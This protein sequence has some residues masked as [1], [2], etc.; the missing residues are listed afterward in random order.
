MFEDRDKILEE[1]EKELSFEEKEEDEEDEELEDDEDLSYDDESDEDSEDDDEEEEEDEEEDVVL[2]EDE[3][4][5]RPQ[6]RSKEEKTNFAFAE[7]RKQN[8][9][10][11]DKIDKLNDVAITYG[12]KDH[13][14][15]LKKLEE[16]AIVKKAKEQ[17]IDPTL[18]KRM[19]EQEKQLET[20]KREREEEKTAQKATIVLT[21]VNEFIKETGLPE[22]EKEGL[23]A[24]LDDDGFTIDTLA[25]IKNYKALFKGYV[26]D[27][28]LE[29]ERQKELAR[30]AKKKRLEEKKFKD[31]GN[32]A[33]A[34]LDDIINNLIKTRKN[35]YL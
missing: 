30:E 8:K 24:A 10:Q 11:K 19:H 2:D 5:I 17:N 28:L 18:Y 25:S 29:T 13:E 35:N 6:K 32:P 12:F 1:L 15:M 7:L 27:K 3:E 34:S 4:P 16:D 9:A 14:D 31:T 22:S 20:L 33:E 21:R 23:I 26:A